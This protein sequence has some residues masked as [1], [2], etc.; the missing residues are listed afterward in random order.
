M[1]LALLLA[2]VACSR[3]EPSRSSPRPDR[4]RDR[5]LDAAVVRSPIPTTA[6]ELVVGVVDDWT[7]TVVTLR[8]FQRTGDRWQLVGEPWPGV[9]GRSGV[10]WGAGLHGD[11]A[12]A[13]RAGPVKRE[14]DGKSPAG[15]FAFRSSYG[16]AAAP[17]S[18][19]KLPYTSLHADHQCVDDPASRHYDR[20]L[21][22]RTVDAADWKSHE[23]MRRDDELYRWVVDVAHNPAHAPGGG[24]CIFLHVWGGPKSS[25]AGCTAMAET[26]LATL[27]ATL[28]PTAVFVLLPRAEHDALATAWQL[29]VP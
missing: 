9:V 23:V 5:T 27:V 24:S 12:P 29:P 13:G 11:G 17:P 20:I 8:R 10:A 25:T 3:S 22:R 26:Q 4:E 1:K 7:T 18:G 2:L 6:R 16:Y 28:D 21:D 14:G 19:T 15:V